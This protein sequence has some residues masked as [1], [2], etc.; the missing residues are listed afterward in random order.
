MIIS[1]NDAAVETAVLSSHHPAAYSM[2]YGI[3]F[4]TMVPKQLIEQST[5]KLSVSKLYSIEKKRTYQFFFSKWA[6]HH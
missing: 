1:V 6:C 3:S 5:L 2:K 4:D